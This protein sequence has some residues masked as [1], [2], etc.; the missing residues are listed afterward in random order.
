[1]IYE[2]IRNY[3]EELALERRTFT[4]G[5]RTYVDSLNPHHDYKGW[6]YNHEDKKLYR[7]NDLMDTFTDKKRT[8]LWYGINEEDIEDESCGGVPAGWVSKDE[9]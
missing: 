8:D 2:A 1:M 5:G 4:K 7:W 6:F 9:L 3:W